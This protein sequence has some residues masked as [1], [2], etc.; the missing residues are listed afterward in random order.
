MKTAFRFIRGFISFSLI[1]A[2]IPL[3]DLAAQQYVKSDFRVSDATGYSSSAV[4]MSVSNNGEMAVVW[5]SSGNEN[6]LLKTIASR[7]ELLSSQIAV[8]A[9]Y[10]T[11]ETRV[12]YNGAGNFMVIFGAYS[13][14]W[15]VM[16]QT[17]S[18]AGDPIGDTLRVDRNTTEMIDMFTSSLRSNRNDQFAAFL[19]GLDSMIVEMF[20]TSGE[21][22]SSTIILKPDSQNFSGMYGQMTYT[23]DLIL[24]WLDTSVGNY[25]GRIF[26]GDGT[27]ATDPFQISQKTPNSYLR[28]ASLCSDT[29]GNFAVVWTNTEDTRVDIYAQ[30]FSKEGVAIGGNTKVTGD[31]AN[32]LG[33]PRSAGMDMDGNFVIAWP[34]YRDQDTSFIY[35]QQMDKLGAPVGDNYRATTINNGGPAL[36]T[37]LPSQVHPAVRVLRDTIY[38]AWINLNENES[39]S[40]EVYASILEWKEPDHT[41][42]GQEGTLQEA[43]YLYPNPSTGQF[44]LEWGHQPEGS[45]Q[46]SIYNSSGVLLHRETRSMSG[47]ELQL[48]LPDM[49]EGMYYLKIDGE[50]IHS[51]LPLIIKK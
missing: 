34:D 40:Q 22:L 28:D 45:A 14:S 8:D 26:S 6:I 9:P 43:F 29:S 47:K 50:S 17:Y 39:T 44:Y 48:D 36:F 24:L 37:T 4:R 35:M 31:E 25:W 38:L 51:S 46:I 13:G 49:Q 41:G 5:E 10:T 7:G 20:S 27:P 33:Y 15:K 42:L 23:G 21:F 2:L 19:P 18:P 3:T 12:A 16:G 30:L 32:Y 11:S 1:L